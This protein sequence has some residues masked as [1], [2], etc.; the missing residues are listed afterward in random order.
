MIPWSNPIDALA[1]E[2]LDTPDPTSFPDDIL[3]YLATT[4]ESARAI[5]RVDLVTHITTEMREACPHIVNL[6]TS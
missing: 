3:G 5:Y 6:L 4:P 1:P 2:E